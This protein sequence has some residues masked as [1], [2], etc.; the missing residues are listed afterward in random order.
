MS[1]AIRGIMKINKYTIKTY[2]TSWTKNNTFS[3]L[4]HHSYIPLNTFIHIIEF[5]VEL[6]ESV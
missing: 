1:T 5:F 4:L 3:S 6:F 2:E